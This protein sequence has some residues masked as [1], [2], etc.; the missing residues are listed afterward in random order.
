MTAMDPDNPAVADVMRL[1]GTRKWLPGS[2]DGF[3]IFV[4]A[5]HG[6]PPR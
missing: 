4:E 2:P 3:E 6:G 5:P 1:E